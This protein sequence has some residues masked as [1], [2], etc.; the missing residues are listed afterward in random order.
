MSALVAACV[1]GAA[2][3]T[4][5]A[6]GHLIWAHASRDQ[7]YGRLLFRSFAGALVGCVVSVLLLRGLLWQGPPL[8]FVVAAG[9]AVFLMLCA[10][11]LY[12]PFIF[13]V[14]SSLS[15]DT[16]LML[17]RA[18]GE[19][20][21]AALYEHL[22]SPDAVRRRLEIMRGNGLVAPTSGGS[23]VLTRKAGPPARFFT[24]V[25]RFWKLW[26]GG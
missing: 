8:A 3:F 1:N 16:L 4:A 12:I 21:R 10:F 2:W 9:G 24:A 14:S 11:V 20:P 22:T 15:I 7:R 5:F 18:G 25:K 13:V 26:P 17:Q 23:Y 6:L 19:L